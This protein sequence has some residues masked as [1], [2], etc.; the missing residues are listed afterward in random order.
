RRM[1]PFPPPMSSAQTHNDFIES[2]C[3]CHRPRP[4]SSP[5]TPQPRWSKLMSGA[6]DF[7]LDAVVD[8]VLFDVQADFG[9]R[10]L[11]W[12]RRWIKNFHDALENVHDGRF[13]NV[14]PDFEFQLQQDQFLGE[15]P[16][17]LEG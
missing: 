3:C 13:M 11:G 2:C 12:W 10:R 7:S 8:G 9:R 14:Q 4:A 15:F 16:A 6:G 17:V 1:E 5:P